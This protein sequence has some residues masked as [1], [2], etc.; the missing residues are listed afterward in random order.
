MEDG[1]LARIRQ[2]AERRG[3]DTRRQDD[4]LLLGFVGATLQE[5]IPENAPAE[6]LDQYMALLFA[7]YRFWDTGRRLYVLSE[8][9]TARLTTPSYAMGDWRLAMPPACYVQLPYQ[10]VWA[11]VDADAPFE[12][13]DGYFASTDD[14]APADGVAATVDI[15]LVLGLRRDRPGLSLIPHRMTVEAREAPARAE[16]PPRDGGSAFANV[17]PGG[18]RR[19]YRAL[20]DTSELEALVLRT[21]HALDRESRSLVAIPAPAPSTISS[22]PPMTTLPSV[23]LP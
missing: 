16:H 9:A 23:L 21:A 10:R 1:A 6:A 3:R 17:L 12:P 4:F 22:D 8:A 18:E 19:D 14:T 15:L 11:R 5:M 13:V 20:V 2:E 7:G